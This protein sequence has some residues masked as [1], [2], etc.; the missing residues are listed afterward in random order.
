MGFMDKIKGLFKKKD[1]GEKPAKEAKAAPAKAKAAPAKAAARADEFKGEGK[2]ADA[3]R[4]AAA[5]IDAK[6]A[7]GS[8]PE[9][10]VGIFMG[11]L[12]AVEAEDAPEDVKI[13]EI[14]QIIGGIVSVGF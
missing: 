7:D 12:K 9:N 4:F 6:V 3:L 2:V 10:K 14:G 13:I 5:K 8:M 1:K 11:A